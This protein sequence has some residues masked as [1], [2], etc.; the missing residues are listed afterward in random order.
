MHILKTLVIIAIVAA[1]LTA[2]LIA[3]YT[4]RQEQ[5]EHKEPVYNVQ[6]PPNRVFPSFAQPR[7]LHVVD[8]R[9]VDFSMDYRHLVL[10]T[11]Q[12]LVNREQARLYIIFKNLDE[13]WLKTLIKYRSDIKVQYITPDDAL[14]M[15]S[16]YARGYIVYD[17]DLPDTVNVATTMAGIYNCTV[18]HP[19]DVPWVERFGIKQFADLRGKFKSRY[20]AYSWAYENLWP[21]CDHR[22]LVPMCPGPPVE[23]RLMQIA[24]RDYAVALKLFVHYLDPNDPIERDLFIKLLAEMPENSAVLGWH[25]EDE[26]ITV[27]L[28]SCYRKFVVVMA[29]HYGPLDFANPTVWSG[30]PAPGEFSFAPSPIKVSFLNRLKNKGIF[31]TFY[32][33]DGDNLQFDYNLKRFWDD[34]NRG[35]VPVAWTISPFLADVAPFMAWYYASTATANDTFVSGPS[36]AGYWYPSS[37]SNYTNAYL[38]VT[39]NYF[40]KTGLRFVE[41]L[42]Y[43]DLDAGKYMDKLDIIAIKMEYNELRWEYFAIHNYICAKYL[44]KHPIPVIFG[45]LHYSDKTADTFVERVR[46]LKKLGRRPVFVLV[47]SQPWDFEKGLTKLKSIADAI[48]TIDEVA[49]INFHEFSMLLNPKYGYEIVKQLGSELQKEGKLTDVSDLDKIL[50]QAISFIEKRQWKDAALKVYEA[51]RYLSNKV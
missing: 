33:T 26:M 43:N 6:W 9:G 20:E 31:L 23:P 34:P 39:E 40:N 47:I 11:L 1:A 25:G 37:N 27:H 17:P 4:K 50:S 13:D 14:K 38:E 12:G 49:L 2:V 45:V 35:K 32:V 19:R 22:L 41:I 7:E 21:K 3:F 30:I 15:F 8:L 44:I 29:H 42:G 48:S 51:F 24:V 36:G 28:A 46:E 16:R 5:V 18:V 10:V